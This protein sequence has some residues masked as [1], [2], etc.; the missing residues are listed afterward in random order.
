MADT[1]F[2][3]AYREEFIPAFEYGQSSLRMT[4]V[5]EANVSGNSAVFLVAGTGSAAAVT[6][7][8]N[9]LI[10]A[11]ADDLTQNTA[12][13]QE[14]HDKPRKT[15]FNANMSQ[16][17]QRRIMQQGTIKVINRK[18]DDDI[19]AQLDTATND[20]GAY[21]TAS[22]AMVAKS[23][24]ILGNNDVDIEEEDKMFGVIT[25]AFRAYLSQTKE[26]ASGE[27]VDVKPLVGPTR[28]YFRWNG[29]NW[30]VTSRLTG[31]GSAQEKCY[32]YHQDSIGHAFDMEGMD[33]AAGY[34]EEDSYYWAR[35]SV[36]MGSK[37][38]QNSGVVQMKHDG[39]AYVAS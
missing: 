36:F 17:D 11:R 21:A 28:R 27:Y 39:S 15:K 10:P 20:T 6:R 23:Q 14:W 4:C 7:G 12:T 24:T 29:I 26:W 16:G 22:L 8:V 9:G 38:L 34:N 35:C 5:T 25:P 31:T 19:I 2:Q 32:L 18:I 3:T 33:M 30:I 37:L 13:L 1:A